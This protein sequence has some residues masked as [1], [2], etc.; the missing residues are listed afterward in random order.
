M[1]EEQEIKIYHIV[2]DISKICRNYF[3]ERKHLPKD[4]WS[5]DDVVQEMEFSIK[6]LK[7]TYNNLKKQNKEE[8]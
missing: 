1:S 7:E 5:V 3:Y 2:C 4:W 6:E 8:N